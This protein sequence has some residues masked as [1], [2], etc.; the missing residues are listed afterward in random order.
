MLEVCFKNQL[1]DK[2]KENYPKE[3]SMIAKLHTIDK[4]LTKII[5]T[6]TA[7]TN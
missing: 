7:K 2:R 5:S 1:K 6:T 4:V 3:N